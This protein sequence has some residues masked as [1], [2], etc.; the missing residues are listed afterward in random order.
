[1]FVI[2]RRWL[3]GLLGLVWARYHGTFVENE[4]QAYGNARFETRWGAIISI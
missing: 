2:M 4:G 1:M 3:V